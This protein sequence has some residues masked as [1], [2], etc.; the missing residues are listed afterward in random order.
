[1]PSSMPFPLETIASDINR[2]ID[3]KLY[4]PALLVT[5]TIPEICSALA[6]DRTQFVKQKHY[7]GFVDSY[8]TPPE[9]GLSG[10]DCYRLRGGV[11]HRADFRGHPHFDC[12]HVIFTTPETPVHMHAF[13]IEV[14]EKTA[15]M[16]DI[17][18][19]C[20]AMI[21]GARRWYEDNKSNPKIEENL[22]NLISLRP[23]GLSPFVKGGPVV[24]SG[25]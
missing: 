11:V 12:T 17:K 23:T 7:I 18:M 19:F 16:F 8:T 24:A 9:L 13:S 22:A 25:Q 15:A 3:A 2:A 6:L 21:S 4:Y 20:Q 10:V 14:G 5:L 1:M